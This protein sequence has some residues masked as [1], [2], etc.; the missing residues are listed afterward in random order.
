[1]AEASSSPTPNTPAD[2]IES[3]DLRTPWLAALLTWLVPGAGQVYQ[4]R[5]FKGALFGI[6]ILGMFLLG[7]NLGEGRTV[8]LNYHAQGEGGML[9]KRNYGYLSQF[10][11]GVAAMPAIVQSK[12]F[13]SPDN[14]WGLADPLEG[15]FTGEVRVG[16]D[17]DSRKQVQGTI[18]LLPVPGSGGHE[19]EGRFTGQLLETGEALDLQLSQPR[20][21]QLRQLPVG[22]AI[23]ASPKREIHMWIEQ[24]EAGPEGLGQ[25]LSGWIPRPFYNWLMVPLQDEQ[26]QYLNSQLGRRWELAMMLTWV[27]GLL[28]IFAIWDAY[29]GPA[30]GIRPQSRRR[31]KEGETGT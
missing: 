15:Q 25:N 28:N 3:V 6:C 12:R 1:M 24:V 16:R 22:L 31:E 18:T 9:R 30:Y 11:V 29:E 8:Y 20:D 10:M 17:P 2:G 13:E 5:Y 7:M 14:A 26:L 27:A 21:H 23:T 4:R 19:I